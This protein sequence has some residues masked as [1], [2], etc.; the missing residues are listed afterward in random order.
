MNY[1]SAAKLATQVVAGLGV[2]RIV[3]EI[4][5]NN[6]A[7]ATTTQAVTVKVGGFVLGSMLMEQSANHIERSTN[8]LVAWFENKRTDK[9]T[10]Q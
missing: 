4:I 7:I 1:L 5:R 10:E 9:E 8:D 2:S 6:V 3:T